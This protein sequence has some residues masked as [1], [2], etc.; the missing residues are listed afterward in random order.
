MG[1]VA[2][3]ER[4]R[5]LETMTTE[6]LWIALF[7]LNFLGT[8]IRIERPLWWFEWEKRF[9][10]ALPGSNYP[11]RLRASPFTDLVLILLFILG[12]QLAAGGVWALLLI[13]FGIW[14]AFSFVKIVNALLPPQRKVEEWVEPIDALVVTSGDET[15]T[16]EEIFLK[17][18]TEHLGILV[19]PPCR[20]EGDPASP[21]SLRLHRVRVFYRQGGLGVVYRF[22][23]DPCYV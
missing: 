21:W 14:G 19:L 1:A 16:W 12:V 5:T 8:F 23:F 11:F 4:L 6:R 17:V 10:A 7:V 22:S 15:A 18:R 3:D 9:L 2:P 13:L 20:Y